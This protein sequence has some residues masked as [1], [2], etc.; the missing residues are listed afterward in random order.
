MSR[1]LRREKKDLLMEVLT[2]LSSAK[3]SRLSGTGVVTVLIIFLSFSTSPSS[4]SR[5]FGWPSTAILYFFLNS[6]AKYLTSAKSKFLP[7]SKESEAFDKTF[8]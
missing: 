5:R 1:S 7:P 4:R 2:S 6:S 3:H 8:F